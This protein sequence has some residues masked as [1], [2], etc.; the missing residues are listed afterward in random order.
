MAISK[1]IGRS[2]G[3]SQGFGS[4]SEINAIITPGGFRRC[5]FCPAVLSA[6]VMGIAKHNQ[7]HLRKGDITRE[8]YNEWKSKSIEV[9]RRVEKA[10]KE[11]KESRY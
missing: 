8:Q 7:A 3:R 1:S 2:G 10:R 6:S 4:R 5:R 9:R 11:M